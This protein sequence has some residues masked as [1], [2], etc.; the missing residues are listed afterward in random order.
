VKRIEIGAALRKEAHVAVVNAG[1]EQV[2]RG[3]LRAFD[4]RQYKVQA[5]AHDRLLI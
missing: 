4:I 3:A 2:V 5:S 1:E